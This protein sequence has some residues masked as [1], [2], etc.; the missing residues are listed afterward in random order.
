MLTLEVHNS[1]PTSSKVS[2]FSP[3][4]LYPWQLWKLTREIVK[5]T[6][7][8]INPKLLNGYDQYPYPK[9]TKPYNVW[10]ERLGHLTRS[11]RLSSNL[12]CRNWRMVKKIGML[13]LLECRCCW[14]KT[15]RR[16]M[17]IKYLCVFIYIFLFLLFNL[18]NGIFFSFF[19][20]MVFFLGIWYM[21]FNLDNGII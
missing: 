6:V 4:L 21:I 12:N 15:V 2:R 16:T 5:S 10:R 18:D 11:S 20:Y 9:P 7:V 3:M 1:W 8:N 19:R 13:L 14:V 17:K